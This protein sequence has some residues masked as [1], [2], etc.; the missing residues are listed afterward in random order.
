VIREA[1]PKNGKADKDAN[2][3]AGNAANAAERMPTFR[4]GMTEAEVLARVGNPDVTVGSKGAASPRWTYMPAPGDPETTTML[5]FNK[6]VVVDIDR[7]V[8]KK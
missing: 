6:G 4:V 1:P 7:K 3:K 5:Q 2:A 8:V